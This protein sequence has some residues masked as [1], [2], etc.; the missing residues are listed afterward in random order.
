MGLTST[1]SSDFG[2]LAKNTA[3]SGDRRKDCAGSTP[4]IE[5]IRPVLAAFES[6]CTDAEL[7]DFVRVLQSGTEAEQEVAVQA[8]GERAVRHLG[9]TP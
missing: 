2:G 3:A 9:M 7:R 1:G 5:A 4:P 6:S 8:A